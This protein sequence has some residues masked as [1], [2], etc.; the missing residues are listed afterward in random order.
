MIAVNQQFEK[1]VL[2]GLYHCKTVREDEH[3]DRRLGASR[4][5][6]QTMSVFCPT[7]LV[8]C[9]PSSDMT[10]HRGRVWRRDPEALPFIPFLAKQPNAGQLIYVRASKSKY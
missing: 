1:S 5:G 2:N 10:L 3:V 8:R 6:L 4:A 9:G 7:E